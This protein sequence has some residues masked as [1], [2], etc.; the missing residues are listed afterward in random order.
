MQ[1]LFS[2]FFA[3]HP[4]PLSPP[5]AG[6]MFPG[7]TGQIVPDVSTRSSVLSS[8]ILFFLAF[9][10][11]VTKRDHSF[12]VGVVLRQREFSFRKSARKRWDPLANQHW[13]DSQI[14]FIHQ[15]IPQKFPRQLAPPH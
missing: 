2:V 10:P 12:R 7:K 6:G 8:G 4:P 13:H 11:L 1:A 9:S 14:Q 5:A 15:V 3:C